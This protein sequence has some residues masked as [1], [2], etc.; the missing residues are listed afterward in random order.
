MARKGRHD[1]GLMIQKDTQ[2]KLVWVVRLSHE[3]GCHLAESHRQESGFLAIVPMGFSK[4]N[5]GATPGPL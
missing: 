4:Q 3:G 1:R 5:L 2:G